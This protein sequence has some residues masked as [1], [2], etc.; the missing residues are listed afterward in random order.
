MHFFVKRTA[1]HR[2]TYRITS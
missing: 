2:K 1:K